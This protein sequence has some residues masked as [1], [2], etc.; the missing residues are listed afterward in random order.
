[1]VVVDNVL[2]A[3]FFFFFFFFF[4]LLF[5]YTIIA[6]LLSGLGHLQGWKLHLACKSQLDDVCKCHYVCL[7]YVCVLSVCVYSLCGTS[8]CMTLMPAS[9][10]SRVAATLTRHVEPR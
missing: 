4:L 1:M 5:A 10:S 8:R 2:F 7:C 6:A 3:G 9:E